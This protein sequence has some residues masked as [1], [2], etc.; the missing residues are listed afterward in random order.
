M[1]VKRAIPATLVTLATSAVV[2]A[3]RL[4]VVEG[5]DAGIGGSIVCPI[6]YATWHTDFGFYD[7]DSHNGCHTSSISVP[8]MTEFCIDWSLHRGHFTFSH[9]GYTR[10]FTRRDTQ[11]FS[12]EGCWGV[13]CWRSE[14]VEVLL[15]PLS[16]RGAGMDHGTET[17]VSV[18]EISQGSV[19]PPGETAV[20]GGK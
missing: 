16:L 11:W 18:S 5:C 17:S 6:Y 8:G 4:V 1:H 2:A 12:G 14:W 10:C 13:E 7:I 9:Q 20:L 19:N 15:C 3:D